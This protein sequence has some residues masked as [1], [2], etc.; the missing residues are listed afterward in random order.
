MD[1]KKLE[2]LCMNHPVKVTNPKCTVKK[3][4]LSYILRAQFLP[5]GWRENIIA[6][7]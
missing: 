7:C 5:S 6:F 3:R 1:K 2:F 4:F